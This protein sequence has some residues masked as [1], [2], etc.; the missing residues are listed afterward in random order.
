MSGSHVRPSNKNNTLTSSHKMAENGILVA[1][2]NFCY[3]SSRFHFVTETPQVV[4]LLM[5]V[6]WQLLIVVH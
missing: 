4:K 2:I 3:C 6:T 5:F 1:H